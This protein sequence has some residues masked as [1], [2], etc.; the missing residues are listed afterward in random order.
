MP[1]KIWAVRIN[2]L[3][4]RGIDPICY[5]VRAFTEDGAINKAGKIFENIFG[6]FPQA[7]CFRVGELSEA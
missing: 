1:E 4:D 5:E 6:F 2:S 7:E 3:E